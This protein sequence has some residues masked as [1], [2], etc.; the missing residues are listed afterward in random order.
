MWFSAWPRRQEEHRRAR[1]NWVAQIGDDET[2]IGPFRADFDAGDDPLD[3]A[4][5]LGAVEELLE[6]ADLAV[7]RRS[8]EARLRAGL[9]GFDAPPKVE[10][11]RNAEDVVDAVGPTPVENLGAAIVAVGAQ[12]DFGARPVG[13]DRNSR[14]RKALVSLPPGRL[15]GRRTAVTKR[16]APSNTTIG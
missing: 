4:P 12:Q 9:E 2:R 10:G 13:A 1:E 5:A 15:A 16:P 3:A 14:R 11:R 8:L 7:A 6:T